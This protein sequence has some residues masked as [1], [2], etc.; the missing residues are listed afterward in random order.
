MTGHH[1][2]MPG[3]GLR[4]YL[5]AALRLLALWTVLGSAACSDRLDHLGKPPTVYP[6]GT[7]DRVSTPLPGPERLALA[8]PG[9]ASMPPQPAETVALSPGAS[10]WSP[11]VQV[12]PSLFRRGPGSLLASD[13]A[14]V[15]GDILTVVIEVDDE[16]EISNTTARARTGDD[17]VSISALLGL[18]A[19]ADVVLPGAGTLTPAVSAGSTTTTQ[20]AGSVSREEEITFRLAATV[21]DVLANGHLVIQGS[22]E[23]LI[24]FELRDLQVSGIVRPQDISRENEVPL[25]RIADARVKYGGRGQITDVQQP[26]YGQQIVD[27]VSPF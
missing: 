14:A 26:R 21:V 13:R 16:A 3:A 2:G 24:N 4:H 9:T 12:T 6:A 25:H 15:R 8:A 5:I 7:P 27:L 19:V 23:V 22:Q 1:T 11:A 10:P 17:Q 18:P 20:G